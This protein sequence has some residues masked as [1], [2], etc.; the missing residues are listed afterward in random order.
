[1]DDFLSL[2]ASPPPGAE[3]FAVKVRFK[4]RDNVELM[5]VIPFRASLNGFEGVLKNQPR[6][7]PSL[8]WGQQVKFPKEDIV[9]WSYSL[10][11]KTYGQFTTCVLFDRNPSQEALKAKSERGFVCDAT[12]KNLGMKAK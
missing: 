12:G 11:G 6:D 5:W 2:R 9:D 10:A 4:Y 1:L 7:N 3:N 8:S